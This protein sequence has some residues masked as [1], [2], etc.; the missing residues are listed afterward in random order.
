MPERICTAQSVL[1]RL[2]WREDTDMILYVLFWIVVD[3]TYD[4][5][6][7][8]QKESYISVTFVR[9]DSLYLATNESIL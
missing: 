7:M 5:T 1:E 3:K 4:I 9:N 2:S 6:R 8:G